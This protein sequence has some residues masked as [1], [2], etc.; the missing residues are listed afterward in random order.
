MDRWQE[1][2]V[3]AHGGICKYAAAGE[4]VDCC[5]LASSV[6]QRVAT[7]R[8]YIRIRHFKIPNSKNIVYVFILLQIL[9][10]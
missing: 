2:R 6:E 10:T 3:P 5:T 8:F 4:A 9:N 7:Q 1:D